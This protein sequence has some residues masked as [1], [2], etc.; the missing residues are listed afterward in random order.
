M[1]NAIPVLVLP[2]VSE[3]V[4]AVVSIPF[5]WFVASVI[6]VLV[7]TTKVFPDAQPI[8]TD[9][10]LASQSTG[11]TSV[12]EVAKTIFQVPVT[13]LPDNVV[14]V[15]SDACLVASSVLVLLALQILVVSVLASSTTA[16][17]IF[18]IV[19]SLGLLLSDTSAI[20]TRSAATGVAVAV[21]VGNI[22]FAILIRFNKL[23]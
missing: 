9:V 20:I 19:L 15:A 6:S 17:T 11:V 3:C 13:D 14:R 23:N 7:S 5:L 4:G 18:S 1:C 10:A 22:V 21:S 16:N 12:G 8:V 2:K